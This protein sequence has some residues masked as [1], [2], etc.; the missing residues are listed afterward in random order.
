[1]DNST[2]RFTLDL[3][4]EVSQVMLSA[5]KGDRKRQIA[6]RFA[7]GGQPFTV[8]EGAY[9][10]FGARRVKD[11]LV[12]FGDCA[13]SGDTV[14]YSLDAVLATTIGRIDC[15]IT[16]YTKDGEAI[17]SPKFGITVYEGA[18]SC[19][20]LESESGYRTLSELVTSAEKMAEDTAAAHRRVEELAADIEGALEDV[21]EAAESVSSVVGGIEQY[22]HE[23]DVW[24]TAQEA[25]IRGYI[26][27]G[28][29]HSVKDIADFEK[30]V[31]DYITAH[32]VSGTVKAEDIEGLTAFLFEN[33]FV[34]R[35]TGSYSGDGTGH[36]TEIYDD[37]YYTSQYREIVV[38]SEEA[39][40]A[41]VT[42]TTNYG[43][44]I[45]LMQGE[46]LVAYANLVLTEYVGDEVYEDVVYGSSLGMP[47]VRLIGNKLY[48]CA[49]IR[50]EDP[51]YNAGYGNDVAFCFAP[52]NYNY[53]DLRWYMN[54]FNAT[55]VTYTWMAE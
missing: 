40:P 9:A 35:L 2:I 47:I 33:G 30:G 16:I 41:K 28:H 38:G 52:N 20:E 10:V 21:N 55:G 3:R 1:M 24:M 37:Q 45:T 23:L 19:E 15:D 8:P 49:N 32:G 11:G 36:V 18:T 26:N 51:N 50:L 39:P 12:L 44:S 17:T 25:T 7:D 53:A 34:R 31:S 54:T 46:E 29:S 43:D 48:V 5:R 27:V 14:T 13:L 22:F 42:I 6:V 4:E